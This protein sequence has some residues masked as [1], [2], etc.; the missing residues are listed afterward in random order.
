MFTG[1]YY[2]SEIGQYYMRARQYDPQLMRFTGRDLVTGEQEYP[3]TL[4]KYLYCGN[5]SINRIDPSGKFAAEGLVEFMVSESIADSLRSMGVQFDKNV[6][7][8][9]SDKI[10]I[11]SYVNLQRGVTMDLFVASWDS[12]LKQTI[13]D[14][15][16]EALGLLSPSLKTLASFV[17]GVYDQRKSI[18]EVLQGNESLGDY[19]GE[20]IFDAFFETVSKGG[21]D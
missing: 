7:D 15:G 1:Q 3:L 4:H 17:G 18:M 12:D 2:D 14:S 20:N 8:K 10:D 6:F 19:I 16:I 9:I 11:F 21:G 13:R 5:D